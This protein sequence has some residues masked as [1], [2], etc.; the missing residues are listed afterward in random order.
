MR[1]VAASVVAIGLV[2]TAVGRQGG[3]TPQY[4]GNGKSVPPAAPAKQDEKKPVEPKKSDPKQGVEVKKEEAKPQDPVKQDEPEQAFVLTGITFVSKPGQVFVHAKQLAKALSQPIILDGP[5]EILTIGE[6]PFLKFERLYNGDVILPV[7]D[8]V[9]LNADV[10]TEKGVTK[11]ITAEAEIPIVVGRKRV[12]VDKAA[13]RLK[14]YQGDI[15]VIDTNVSTG[16]PGHNTS[17]GTFKTRT[18]ERMHY[19]RKYNNSPMP[20]SIQFNGD[21]FFHGYTSV[22]SYPASHGCV[23]IPLDKKN[24]ARYLWHWVDIGVEVKV[25]GKYD[26]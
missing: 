22:P 23:R 12:E 13:Q 24:P 15:V 7:K 25:F 21:I 2:V 5:T 11:L 9:H 19:S 8:L 16:A 3:Y 14:G 4:S 18:R 1:A 6:V 10:V 20:W 26:W 17:N